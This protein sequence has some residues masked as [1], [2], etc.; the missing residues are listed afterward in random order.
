QF[1]GLA[2]VIPLPGVIGLL[3]EGPDPVDDRAL[4]RRKPRGGN[5]FE[6]T[7][8][9]PPPRVGLFTEPFQ[10][11]RGYHFLDGLPLLGGGRSSYRRR[12]H[13]FHGLG[14]RLRRRMPWRS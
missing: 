12:H 8:G 13:R 7:N 10:F 9:I 4:A 11:I 1:I 14:R 6:D 3:D 2:I 5:L